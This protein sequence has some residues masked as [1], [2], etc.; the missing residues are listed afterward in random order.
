MFAW[1]IIWIS[2]SMKF[3]YLVDVQVLIGLFDYILLFPEVHTFISVT[4]C[5]LSCLDLSLG[6]D[7]L[8]NILVIFKFT[9][10]LIDIYCYF[11]NLILE[12]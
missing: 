8:V 2:S 3:R 12:L 9:K 4:V 5:A 1:T 10:Y 7:S 11:E 6:Y